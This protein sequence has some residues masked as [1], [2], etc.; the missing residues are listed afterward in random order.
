MPTSQA[1]CPGLAIFAQRYSASPSPALVAGRTYAFISVTVIPGRGSFDFG[2]YTLNPADSSFGR[3][4]EAPICASVLKN[5]CSMNRLLKIARTATPGTGVQFRKDKYGSS[6]IRSF[7]GEIIHKDLSINV[8][9]LARL[10][11]ARLFKVPRDHSFSDRTPELV[12][13]LL[14]FRRRVRFELPHQP[15]CRLI[16]QQHFSVF[17]AQKPLGRRM[18]EVGQQMIEVTANI[19]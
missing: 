3:I 7:P 19:Q 10:T 9:D 15:R 11:H 8:C 18:V 13:P 16:T 14:N 4:P 1:D 2:Q 12:R 6:G 17:N 5:V